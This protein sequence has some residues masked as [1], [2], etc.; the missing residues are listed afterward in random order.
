[1]NA[2]S[3]EV[4]TSV[5]KLFEDG[6]ISH[7]IGYEAGS[8]SLH[9]TPCFLKSGQAASRLVWNPLCAHNLSKYLLDFKKVEGKVGIMVK[10]CDSRSVV[11]LLKENQINRDKVFI[12]GIPCSGI[13]DTEKLLAVLGISPGEVVAVEDDG[14]AF[15]VT[16]KEGTRRV[17]KEQVLRGECLVCKYPTPLIYDVLLGE[18]VSGLPW[19][20]DDYSRVKELETLSA[21]D[22]ERYWKQELSQCIRCYACRNICPVCNCS[23]CIFDKKAP[24][25]LSKANDVSENLVY[26][27]IRAFHVAGR[28][29]DCGEC[30]RA[31]P[32]NIPLRSLN[33]KVEKDI[34]EL[35]NYTAGID[36]EQQPPLTTYQ[37]G[38]LDDFL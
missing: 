14:D 7:F 37:V 31:C 23:E 12:V 34:L 18:A 5:K 6:S 8:D 33:K 32:M 16:I 38:D 29:V 10:G 35:F 1:M 22:K 15:L 27:L 21:A 11:E 24:R 28:C 17:G 26:H 4:Q 25:W 2:T 3:E 30:E 36:V 13:V 20:G 19:V 9:V